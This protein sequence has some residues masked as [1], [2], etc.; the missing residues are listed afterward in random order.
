MPERNHANQAPHDQVASRTTAVASNS[1]KTDAIGEVV[2]N[3]WLWIGAT[4]AL[5]A[6][7]AFFTQLPPWVQL[8][9]DPRTLF[10]AVFF[11]VIAVFSIHKQVRNF[12]AKN[13]RNHE[14]PPQEKHPER[15]GNHN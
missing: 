12:F 7:F 6:Y 5:G 13:S 9:F 10:I 8:W 2:S 14:P 15:E 4:L 11:V 3:I 1:S